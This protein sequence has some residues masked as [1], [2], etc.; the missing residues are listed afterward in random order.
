MVFGFCG[1]DGAGIE[2][3]LNQA[4]VARQ[5]AK[6]PAAQANR[7]AKS[8][9]HRQAKWSSRASSTT[10]VETSMA[11]AAAPRRFG[12]QGVVCAGEAQA[13]FGQQLGR[14]KPCRNRFQ[15]RR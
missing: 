10:I 4:V 5:L 1:A 15:R 14:A 9:A 3:L 8:P 13:D 7:P 2:Q 11:C 6:A 12:P